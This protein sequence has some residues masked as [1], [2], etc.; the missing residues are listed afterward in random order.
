[1]SDRRF[2]EDA[3]ALWRSPSTSR[4]ILNFEILPT[5]IASLPIIIIFRGWLYTENCTTVSLYKLLSTSFD[6]IIGTRLISYS[7]GYNRIV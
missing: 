4:T 6:E 7:F 1:M 3:T 5:R 2:Y